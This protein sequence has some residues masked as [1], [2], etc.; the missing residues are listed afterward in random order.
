MLRKELIIGVFTVFTLLFTFGTALAED[1]NDK[2]ILG[3][4]EFV[5]GAPETKA[6]VAARDYVYDEKQLALIGTEAGGEIA[7]TPQAKSTAANHTYDDEHLV[8]ASTEAGDWE[9]RFDVQG[10]EKS[11]AV[12]D[13]ADKQGA[14]CSNC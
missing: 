11:E 5:F 13:K 10:A 14:T 2:S 12:A 9:Y 1:S 8:V 3:T 6:D 7:S 4:D